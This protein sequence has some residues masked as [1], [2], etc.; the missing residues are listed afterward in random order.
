M[1]WRFKSEEKPSRNIIQTCV[2]E[3][4]MI[5]HHIGYWGQECEAYKNPGRRGLDFAVL[6]SQKDPTTGFSSTGSISSRLA[7]IIYSNPHPTGKSVCEAA[8]H[9][10]KTFS[11]AKDSASCTPQPLSPRFT[12]YQCDR[13]QKRCVSLYAA[14]GAQ[15]RWTHS[16]SSMGGTR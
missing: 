9:F 16:Q 4:G 7:P 12:Q 15:Q 1:L 13:S 6:P 10:L 2:R 5:K 14:L 11:S 8:V 3:T